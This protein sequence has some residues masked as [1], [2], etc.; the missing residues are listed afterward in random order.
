MQCL[1]NIT[2]PFLIK[3]L[4]SKMKQPFTAND[5]TNKGFVACNG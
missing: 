2:R 3:E 4:L 5:Y 1:N